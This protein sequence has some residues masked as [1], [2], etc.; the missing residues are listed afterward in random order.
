MNVKQK[1]VLYGAP[2]TIH[3]LVF[4]GITINNKSIFVSLLP[5]FTVKYFTDLSNINTKGK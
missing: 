1:Q 4:E 3:A 5:S 2:H